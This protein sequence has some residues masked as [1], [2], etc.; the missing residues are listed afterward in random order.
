MTM[1]IH[2]EMED[3]RELIRKEVERVYGIAI[4]PDMVEPVYERGY[5]ETEIDGFEVEIPNAEMRKVSTPGF[6]ID[7]S[8]MKVGK[9]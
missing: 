5:D 8:G 4:T 9:I 2:F 1:K 7:A 6:G 3:I